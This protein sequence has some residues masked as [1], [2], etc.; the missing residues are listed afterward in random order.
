MLKTFHTQLS[1][2]STRIKSFAQ[3]S[4]TNQGHFCYPGPGHMTSETDKK[5]YTTDFTRLRLYFFALSKLQKATRKVADTQK[6][7]SGHTRTD[8]QQ[9][10]SSLSQNAIP[11]AATRSVALDKIKNFVLIANNVRAMRFIAM[12]KLPTK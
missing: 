9:N 6:K 5:G 11:L 7:Q 3:W 8:T 1:T 4:Y 12:C 2:M 10:A